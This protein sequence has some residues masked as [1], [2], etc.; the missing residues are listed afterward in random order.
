MTPDDILAFVRDTGHDP[1]ILDL[2]A[3]SEA[4]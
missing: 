4:D 2:K 3:L 1:L